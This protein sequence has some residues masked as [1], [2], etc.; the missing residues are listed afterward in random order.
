MGPS[1]SRDRTWDPGRWVGEG[2]GTGPGSHEGTGSR[3]ESQILKTLPPSDPVA[4][5][6]QSRMSSGE[7]G[8]VAVR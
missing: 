6:V 3:I 8:T 2:R 7:A 5:I 1:A 4:R